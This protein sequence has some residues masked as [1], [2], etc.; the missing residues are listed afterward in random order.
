MGIGKNL[1]KRRSL[2][3]NCH[4]K[5]RYDREMK[6]T[7]RVW[8]GVFAV[9]IAAATASAQDTTPSE[10]GLGPY[11]FG[12]SLAEAQATTP[13]ASWHVDALAGTQ[14]LTGGPFLQ[15]GADRFLASLIFDHDALQCGFCTPGFTVA[16]YAFVR[17]HPN[18]TLEDVRNGLGGNLCRCGTYAGITEAALELAKKGVR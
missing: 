18:A 3:H 2:A 14:A 16:T 1:C 11:H 6:V 10:N 7:T 9:S 17:D 8:F 12:M 4:S 13:R 5:I 15:V